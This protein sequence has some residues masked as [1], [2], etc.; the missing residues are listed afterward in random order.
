MTAEEVK[1]FLHARPFVPFALHL[2]DGRTVAIDDPQFTRFSRDYQRFVFNDIGS[3]EIYV[4]LA[5]VTRAEL[6]GANAQVS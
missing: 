5:K 3:H 6:L 2:A 1:S 4:W